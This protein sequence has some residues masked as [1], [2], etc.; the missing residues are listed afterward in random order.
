MTCVAL[1]P[2]EFI[3]PMNHTYRVG[4]P[5]YQSTKHPY[6]KRKVPNTIMSLMYIFVTRFLPGSD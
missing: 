4:F 1:T 3:D 5:K 2:I 6:Q